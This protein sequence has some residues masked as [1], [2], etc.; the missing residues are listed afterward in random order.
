LSIIITPIIEKT[1]TTKKRLLTNF[2]V[3]IFGLTL[4]AAA[5]LVPVHFFHRATR[6]RQKSSRW[7]DRLRF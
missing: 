7:R 4:L 2:T 6:L 5:S 1:G 3:G